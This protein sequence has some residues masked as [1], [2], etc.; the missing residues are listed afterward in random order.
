MNT[1]ARH[2]GVGTVLPA[3]AMVGA[4]PP[5]QSPGAVPPRPGVSL[6]VGLQRRAR[7]DR[8]GAL[9]RAQELLDLA[10]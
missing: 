8:P 7:Q 9:P 4:K 3:W 10:S 1:T 5:H 6:S 2:D